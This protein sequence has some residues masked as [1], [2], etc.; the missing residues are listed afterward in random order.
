MKVDL[1]IYGIHSIRLYIDHFVPR[2]LAIFLATWQ[3]SALT[4]DLL[5]SGHLYVKNEITFRAT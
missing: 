2:T 4:E 3:D 1:F 5:P